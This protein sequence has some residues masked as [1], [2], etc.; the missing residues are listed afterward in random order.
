MTVRNIPDAKALGNLPKWAQIHIN[1]I[2]LAMEAAETALHEYTDSTT[3]SPFEVMDLVCLSKTE[4]VKRYV[5][6]SSMEVHSA[7]VTVTIYPEDD[8]VALYFDGDRH[9]GDVALVPQAANSLKIRRVLYP[10]KG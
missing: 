6:A 8:G 7:G 4:T 1:D 3:P 9:A 5:Q 2:R 10:K